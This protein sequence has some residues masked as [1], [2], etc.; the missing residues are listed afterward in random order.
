[1]DKHEQDPDQS[2]DCGDEATG[3]GIRLHAANQ[4]DGKAQTI[5]Q[6][7]RRKC[8][9]SSQPRPRARKA[10]NESFSTIS[11]SIT[12]VKLCCACNA[13]MLDA[14]PSMD[15]TILHLFSQV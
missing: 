2:G 13:C 9:Q 12:N 6:L 15:R 7:S 10:Q 14:V 4:V 11:A 5:L 3:K 8:P 1:M